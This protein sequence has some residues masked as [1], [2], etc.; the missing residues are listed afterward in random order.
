MTLRLSLSV[1][2]LLVSILFAQA[3]APDPLSSMEMKLQHISANAG[4]TPPD[5]TPTELT[6]AEVN[7]YFAAGRVDLPNGVK[8]VVFSTQPGVIS[9]TARVDFDQVRQGRSNYNPLLSVFNGEHN[10]GVIAEAHGAGGQGFVH[11]QK[12]TLDDVE[13]PNFALQMFVEKYVTNK[14]PNVGLDSQFRLPEGI[15]T[16][17]VGSHQV[18][19][20]QK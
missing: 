8:S 10:V 4:A 11:V 9:G 19:V 6:D 1:A 3:P 14:Y 2:W 17:T 5:Q 18:T 13:I 20:T 12:V 16:A 7:A 15:D